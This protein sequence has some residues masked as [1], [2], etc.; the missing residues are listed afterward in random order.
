MTI[1]QSIWMKT[2]NMKI[3]TFVI[4]AT[5]DAD[6]AEMLHIRKFLVQPLEFIVWGCP[7]EVWHSID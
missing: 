5:G 6:Q 3:T 7:I 2:A 1:S 4:I